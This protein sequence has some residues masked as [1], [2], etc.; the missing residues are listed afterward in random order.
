MGL[1]DDVKNMAENATGQDF[2]QYLDKLPEN[3]TEVFDGDFMKN[4]TQFS[5]ITSFFSEGGFSIDKLADI[6]NLPLDQLNKFV[7]EKT[8]FGNW[9]EMLQSA[10]AKFLK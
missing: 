1:F 5:D 8:N 7:G 10:A 4:N 3:I 2:D 6:K 9:Q